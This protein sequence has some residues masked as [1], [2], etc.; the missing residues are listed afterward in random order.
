MLGP[1]N[2]K[3]QEHDQRQN[4]HTRKNPTCDCVRPCGRVYLYDNTLYVLQGTP[5]VLL[6][7]TRIISAGLRMHAGCLD[8]FFTCQRHSSVPFA[9]NF[10]AAASI[11]P[12]T[13]VPFQ[14]P[15]V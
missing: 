8:H 5:P 6:G 13:S 11:E 4:D 14:F 3:Q 2:S 12:T 10:T 1:L 7:P 9:S 15:W